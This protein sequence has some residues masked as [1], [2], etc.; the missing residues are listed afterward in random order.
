MKDLNPSAG[1]RDTTEQLKWV[2]S[3]IQLKIL[4]NIGRDGIG[5]NEQR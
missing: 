5:E 2:R 3:M 4:L 1:Y